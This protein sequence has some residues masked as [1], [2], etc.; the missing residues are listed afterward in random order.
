MQYEQYSRGMGGLGNMTREDL[1]RAVS[2]RMPWQAAGRPIIRAAG[3][4]VRRGAESTLKDA[5]AATPDPTRDTKLRHLLQEHSIAGEKLIRIVEVTKAERRQLLSW[6]QAKR[7]SSH[8]LTDVFPGVAPEQHVV[9]SYLHAPISLGHVALDRGNAAMYTAVRSYLERVEI[10]VNDLKAGSNHG[11]EELYATRRLFVQTFEA[12]WLAPA[13][14]HAF[15]IADLPV[16]APSGFASESQ[17][18]LE[19]EL[20]RQL[21]R[22]VKPKNLWK[23]VEGLYRANDGR[24]VDH[25]FVNNTEAVKSHTA[26]RGGRSL[27]ADPYDR[28]GA[29]AVGDDLL[30]FKVAVAWPR[31]GHKPSLADPEVLLPGTA[32]SLHACTLDH[33]VVRNCLNSRDLASVVSKIL[34]QL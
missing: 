1:L 20:R 24:L 18:F 8:P 22:S 4:D 29:A 31:S 34:A 2:V 28:A 5:L 26:R 32:R 16:K 12:I 7:R 10:S 25:G 13:L 30:T 6:I 14:D 15:L 17:L 27:W 9:A 3:F 33:F 11:Y 19:A 23:A 21:G